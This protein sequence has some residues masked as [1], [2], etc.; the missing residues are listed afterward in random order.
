MWWTFGEPEASIP[1]FVLEDVASD[2]RLE[3]RVCYLFT[4]PFKIVLQRDLLSILK[5][6]RSRLVW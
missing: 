4:V 2:K 3:R 1:S 6:L 5:S